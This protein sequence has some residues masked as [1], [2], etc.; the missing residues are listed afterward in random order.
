MVE[1]AYFLSSEEHGPRALLEQAKRAEEAGFRGVHISDHFHPWTAEQGQS[2]F[3][4][5]VIG[6]IAAQTR[7]KVTTAVTCPTFRVHPAVIAQAAATSQLLLEGRFVLG[8]G[9][10]ENLN[11]H[12]LG[13][14]WPE[15]DVRLE[16]LHEA[17]EVMRNLWDGGLTSHHGKHYTVEN[18]QIFSL[19]DEPPPI[20]MSGFG[21]KSI[22]LAAEIADG[23]IS[24]SPQGLEDYQ[25]AGGKGPS[26][27]GTKVCWAQTEKE[28]VDVAHRLW[29][30]EQLPGQL[31]QE[32]ALPSQFGAATQLVTKETVAENVACG[33]DPERH[34]EQIKK[35][36]DAGYDEVYL[37]QMGYDQEGFFR[38]WE[39]ELAPRLA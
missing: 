22:A 27:G 21:E 8:I 4:W 19:P 36:V 20:L 37:G 25:K 30:V 9:S 29:A 7:L 26:A 11:E 35:F 33:P 1:F 17:V 28:A 32:I 31:N 18:A 34:V 13:Q 39:K 5:S 38:F 14:H 24:T 15:T 23:F 6:A 3:V 10:G 16:M 12:I 2:P